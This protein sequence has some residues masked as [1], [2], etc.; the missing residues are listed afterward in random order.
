MAAAVM[1]VIVTLGLSWSRGGAYR[2]AQ[3]DGRHC[4]RQSFS[5]LGLLEELHNGRVAEVFRI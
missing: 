4:G 5:H 2:A 1:A 3:G